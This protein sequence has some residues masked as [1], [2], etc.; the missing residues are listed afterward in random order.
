MSTVRLEDLVDAAEEKWNGVKKATLSKRLDPKLHHT[1][2]LALRRGISIEAD[3]E[4]ARASM[5]ED[6]SSQDT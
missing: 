1:A 2:T 4:E 5:N 6:Y 3:T